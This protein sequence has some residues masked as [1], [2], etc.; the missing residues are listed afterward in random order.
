MDIEVYTVDLDAGT[1]SSEIS[2]SGLQT[3]DDTVLAS[4]HVG[5][6][7]KMLF[8]KVVTTATTDIVWGGYVTI[9]AT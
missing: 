3:N 9:Q 2:N 5:A 8:I 1:I 7:D 4:N 6:D